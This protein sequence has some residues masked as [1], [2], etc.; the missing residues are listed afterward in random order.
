ML[1]WV[2]NFIAAIS[3]AAVHE[4][5]FYQCDI[6]CHCLLAFTHFMGI[7]SH[8]ECSM[9]AAHIICYRKLQPDVVMKKYLKNLLCA[10]LLRLDCPKLLACTVIA[11]A[12]VSHGRLEIT[13]S[14]L[15]NTN[16][17]H[18]CC[19]QPRENLRSSTNNCLLCQV[20]SPEDA[21]SCSWSSL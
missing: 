13:L 9:V 16:H 7:A 17:V 14:M 11:F 18:I 20:L 6:S 1:P 15:A 8:K 21:H 4:Q 5:V 3:T 10:Q 19:R 2:F 12:A